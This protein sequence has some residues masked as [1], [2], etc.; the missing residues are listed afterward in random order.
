MAK[1]T[2]LK[3]TSQFVHQAS[4]VNFD[5][6]IRERT[7]LTEKQI[8]I[9]KTM[10]AKDTKCVFVDGLWGT[11]KTFCAVL[12]GL[13]L[14][15]NQKSTGII[16]IRNPVESSST[17]KT[18]FLPGG[19]D[20]KMAPYN[21]VLQEKLEEFLS[22]DQVDLLINTQL[23]ECIP[24]G[25]IRGRSWNCKTIIVD[26]A[27]SMT[28]DDLFLILSRCGEFTKIFLIGDSEHQNDIGT[29]SGFKR[30]I[31]QFND[32]ESRENGV[33]SFELKSV[34]DIVRSGFVRFVMTKLGKLKAAP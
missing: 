28:Y 32:E 10:V 21:A 33:F 20:E 23:V 2:K 9:I 18:G 14:L 6:K 3:D 22:K 26:E 13:K 30:M 19:I 15:K 34:S 7:D 31:D 1:K 25:F 24:L 17:G 11:S 16:Y 8:D 12:S 27:S 4:K 29:K 5:L